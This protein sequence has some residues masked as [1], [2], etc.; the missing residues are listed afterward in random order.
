VVQSE[1]ASDSFPG[2]FEVVAHF[3]PNIGWKEESAWILVAG[4]FRLKH[5]VFLPS[6]GVCELFTANSSS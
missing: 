5:S 6:G 1:T 2:E 4:G 3:L